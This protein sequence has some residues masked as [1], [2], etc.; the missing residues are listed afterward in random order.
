MI[1]RR[2]SIIL[3]I[4]LFISTLI[5]YILTF[6]D[7]SLRRVC[8]SHGAYFVLVLLL[9]T[10]VFIIIQ[11]MRHYKPDWR[12]MASRYAVGIVLSMAICVI[13][14]T[15]VKPDFR[16]LSDETNLMAVSKSMLYEKRTDNVTMGLWYYGNFNPVVRQISKR[17][18]LF[19]FMTH[20]LHV[21][22]GYRPG[23]VFVLNFIVMFL[24][25][26]F[27][28]KLI[29]DQYG[30]KWATAGLFL[31]ASQPIFIQNATS[32]GW[33]LMFSLFLIICFM[34]LFWFM[35]KP[36]M[37][38]FELLWMNLILLC[39]AR[40]E[41]IMT[42][43]LVL[44]FLV[45]FKYVKREYLSQGSKLVYALTPC[46]F[47]IIFWQ[48]LLNND[49]FESGGMAPFSH[50]YFIKNNLLFLKDLFDF[51]FFLPYATIINLV[52]FVCLVYIAVQFIRK[53]MI[54]E[55]WKR[56]LAI[57][58]TCCL[59][60]NWVLYTSFHNGNI[61]HPTCARYYAAFFMILSIFAVIGCERL[62]I[63]KNKVNSF[64]SLSM[65][66]LLVYLPVSVEDR[67]SRAQTLPRRYRFARKF[68]LNSLTDTKNVV[69]ITD[70]PGH[71]TVYNY[72]AVNFKHANESDAFVSGW[73]KHLYG[74]IYVIQRIM[75]D[76]SSP[77]KN[78]I[79]AEKFVLRK[80]I[81]SQIRGDSFIR[82]SKVI[83]IKDT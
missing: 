57:I 2:A 1:K 70:R 27:L 12:S 18:L 78:D 63:I 10:W 52:G 42:M 69:F 21:I 41:G 45:A 47:I 65:I 4:I 48:R 55:P 58:S 32:G 6:F 28:Y 40:Y 7:E 39:H 17:H 29:F 68:I 62:P 54:A 34:S 76:T 30:V 16:I 79:L 73:K 9:V 22:S 11:A 74:D 26:V 51:K 37:I 33:D 71:Y 81:E 50:R 23:N 67:F 59:M 77:H 13:A 24:I 75:Y 38:K 3:C 83:T 61:N 8:F 49:T 44:F 35:K 64:I 43:F 31:V 19:P 82:I 36:D 25:L 14:F 56:K 72:G 15:A 20:I 80:L 5:L 46:F 60:A 53:R 66:M